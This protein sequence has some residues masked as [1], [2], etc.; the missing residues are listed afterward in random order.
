MGAAAIIYRNPHY[1]G[2]YFRGIKDGLQEIHSP[3][4]QNLPP[5]QIET[6]AIKNND[7]Q[8]ITTRRKP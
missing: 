1:I 6:K 4:F 2:S 3:S 7:T 5:Y 8:N